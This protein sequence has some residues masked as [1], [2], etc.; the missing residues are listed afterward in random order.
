[1]KNMVPWKW[2]PNC[3]A[4]PIAATKVWKKNDSQIT[5]R[6]RTRL[7]GK[8][9][10]ETRSFWVGFPEKRHAINYL[11]ELH[12]QGCCMHLNKAGKD[13]LW[14]NTKWMCTTS[15]VI[16]HL[17]WPFLFKNPSF[18]KIHRVG[19]A[20]TFFGLLCFKTLHLQR[21]TKLMELGV[22]PFTQKKSCSRIH[23]ESLPLDPFKWW[24]PHGECKGSR[25]RNKYFF[26]HI[27][28]F[29]RMLAS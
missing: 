26:G 20:R 2:S 21:S 11:E 16:D 22:P 1:M 23:G 10:I 5:S 4:T 14:Y 28:L 12:S 18:L 7:L 25:D 27:F 29:L 13:Y 6:S 15:W 3:A 9:H 24:F 17:W 19:I 8:I